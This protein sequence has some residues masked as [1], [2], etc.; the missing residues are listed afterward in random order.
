MHF[1][2]WSANR[3]KGIGQH[4]AASN[5]EKKNERLSLRLPTFCQWPVRTTRQN[6]LPKL[7]ADHSLPNQLGLR[8]ER[9]GTRDLYA[10]VADLR[11]WIR[12]I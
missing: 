1:S 7:T 11:I 6:H 4:F 5:K 9:A 8:T 3:R 12:L 2:A 10:I